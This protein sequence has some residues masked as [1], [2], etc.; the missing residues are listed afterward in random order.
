MSKLVSES[1][2]TNPPSSAPVASD[3]NKFEIKAAVAL[4][5]NLK[6]L[7]ASFSHILVQVKR[8]LVHNKCD[9]SE[10][11]LFLYSTIGTKYFS[12]CDNFGELLKKLQQGHLDVFNISILQQLV[13]CFKNG[14]LT[15]VVEAYN[16]KKENFLKHTTVLEFQRAI[17]SRVEPILASGKAAVTI[18][19]SEEMASHRTLKD[20]ELLAIEG[21]EESQKKFIVLHAEPG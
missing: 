9:L 3:E 14:E 15:E 21:F 16:K 10:A 17:A 13:A 11:K 4:V 1:S 6:E 20:I 7:E 2:A 18:T 12:G 8:L 19:I 5:S